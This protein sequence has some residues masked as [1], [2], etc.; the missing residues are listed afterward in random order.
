[1]TTVDVD[2]APPVVLSVL[3]VNAATAVSPASTVTANFNEAINASTVN[4]TTFQLRNAANNLVAATVS[5]A[6]DKITLIPSAP[7]APLTAY[8]V[9]ITGGV[10][11]TKDLAG[12]ALASDYV[13]TFTTD[14]IDNTPPTITSVSPANAAIGVGLSA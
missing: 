1:F 7:L 12:N 8:T 10:S 11:G 9:T 14:A 13:W 2:I 6:A 3:P 5:T 4:G